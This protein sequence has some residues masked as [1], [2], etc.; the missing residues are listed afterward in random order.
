MISKVVHDE[1]L[2]EHV[3]GFRNALVRGRTCR[4]FMKHGTVPRQS[5]GPDREERIFYRTATT[6]TCFLSARA[7]R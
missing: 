4:P 3:S 6:W 7:T 1:A 5:E 2:V